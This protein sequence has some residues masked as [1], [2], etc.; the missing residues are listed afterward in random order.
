MALH[1]SPLRPATAPSGPTPDAAGASTSA[2]SAS[3]TVQLHFRRSRPR[4]AIPTDNSAFSHANK[5]S[6][7]LNPLPPL[8]S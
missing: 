3:G 4:V 5:A 8:S 1:L 7:S 6:T 2:R